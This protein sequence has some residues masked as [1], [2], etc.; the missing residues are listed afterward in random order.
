MLEYTV[1]MDDNSDDIYDSVA[2]GVTTLEHTESGLTE[3]NSYRFR[4]QAR[5]AVG[6]SNYSVVFTIIA[7][8][9]PSKPGAPTTYLNVD[10]TKVVIDWSA[11]D[12]GGLS[13]DGYKVE[14][15]TSTASFA[16]DLTDCDAETNS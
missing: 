8:T 13:I 16:K 6:F 7:A 10:S 11:P 14:I 3:G 4:V 5:N 15:K 2:T 12:T 9:V 1:E